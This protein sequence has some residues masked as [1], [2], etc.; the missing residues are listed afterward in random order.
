VVRICARERLFLRRFVFL[1]LLTSEILRFA[2]DDNRFFVWRGDGLFS[3]GDRLRSFGLLRTP[4]DD[5]AWASVGLIQ[6][7]ASAY[8]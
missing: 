6:K 7:I 3:G 8:F 4:E 1:V 2:Q 5:S